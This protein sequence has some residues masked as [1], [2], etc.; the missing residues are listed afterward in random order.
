L[1]N[2]NK[3]E[4]KKVSNEKSNQIEKEGNYSEQKPEEANEIKLEEINYPIKQ[5]NYNNIINQQSNTIIEKT[6]E[7]DFLAYLE[8]K[9][10]EYEK[11][12]YKTPVLDYII[13]NKPKLKTSF[14]RITKDKNNHVDH[15]F[16]YLYWLLFRLNS[17]LINFQE[18][19][20]GYFCFF[21]NLKKEFIEGIF[22][23]IDLKFLYEK[24]ISDDNFPPDD[25]YSPNEIIAKNAFKSRALSFE[26]Y[27]NNEIILKQLHAKE[28]Q[29]IIYIFKDVKDI[30]GLELGNIKIEENNRTL[31]VDGV[32]L[33][34]ENKN[35]ILNKIYF[36]SDSINKFKIS[37]ENPRKKTIINYNEFF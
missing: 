16:D 35:I 15:L 12:E 5:E 6:V 18:S 1:I 8:K 36:I 26:Y 14:F 37:T 13:K 33:E 3:E 9:K 34:K 32:I 27:L 7:I 30:E 21:D 20:V 19:K 10:V 22:S 2:L 24:I 23:N 28:R 17:D 25:I 31:E 29:R 4:V 11:M